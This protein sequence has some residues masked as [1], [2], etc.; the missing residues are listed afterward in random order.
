M[1]GGAGIVA[2][3][4]AHV[5]DRADAPAGDRVA[6][7]R[8]DVRVSPVPSSRRRSFAHQTLILLRLLCRR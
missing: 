8:E 5:R 7:C 6:V 3:V 1:A 2:A 4:S